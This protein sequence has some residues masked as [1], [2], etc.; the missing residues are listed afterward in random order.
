MRQFYL[1]KNSCGYYRIHFIDP[2]TG[3]QGTGKSTHT[4][5]LNDAVMIAYNW[6]HNGIPDARS[7]SRAFMN[8]QSSSVPAN[9]KSLVDNISENDAMKVIKMICKKFNFILS[10]V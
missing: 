7:N 9:L 8:S 4:K 10:E 1:S 6:L 5:D 2:I 3:K